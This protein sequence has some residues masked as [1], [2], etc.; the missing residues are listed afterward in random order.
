MT[1]AVITAIA[2]GILCAVIFA[3]KYGKKASQLSEA[4]KRLKEQAERYY[5]AQQNLSTY[6]NMPRHELNRRMRKKRK[7]AIKRMRSKN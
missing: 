7:A 6:V 1:A 5:R 4:K 3:I 2:I